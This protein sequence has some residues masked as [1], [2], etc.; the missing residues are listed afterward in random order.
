MRE[1]L[2]AQAHLQVVPSKLRV[3]MCHGTSSQL[4]AANPTA[5]QQPAAA[6]LNDQSQETVEQSLQ[7]ESSQ[8][9]CQEYE[10]FAQMPSQDKYP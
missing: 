6:L 4:S 7:T 9:H 1:S 10:Q 5:E 3:E 8:Q 2:D